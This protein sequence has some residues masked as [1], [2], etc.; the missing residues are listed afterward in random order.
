M[1]LPEHEKIKRFLVSAIEILL[2]TLE[3]DWE[4]YGS[5][6]FKRGDRQVGVE[7]DDCFYVQHA[8]Q[9]L[10]LRRVDLT[11][12]PPPD[13]AI[14]VNIMSPTRLAAYQRLGVPELW[15]YQNGQVEIWRLQ[16]G[17]YVKSE[18][19][20]VIPNRQLLATIN[21]FLPRL[22]SESVSRLKREFRVWAESQI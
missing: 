6:P 17:Q 21:A 14:E 10:G 18:S 1:P 19:S 11:V 9:M 4:P 3:L 8:A 7:P 2:D 16:A 22:Q 5:T 13:L 12:D 15:R 20:S